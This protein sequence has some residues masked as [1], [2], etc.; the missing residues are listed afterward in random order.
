MA[1]RTRQE[2]GNSSVNF[3]QFQ[4]ILN[5]L[6]INS[7]YPNVHKILF[8]KYHEKAKGR[9]QKKNWDKSVRKM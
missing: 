8:Q 7:A 6:T 4:L 3:S 5:F 2:D 9:R 1:E